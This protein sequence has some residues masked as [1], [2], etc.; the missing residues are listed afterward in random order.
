[1]CTLS[2]SHIK[3]KVVITSNRD[4]AVLRSQVT[5]REI[6]SDNN[7]I[8][9]L[10]DPLKKGT[11]LA[12][13][14]GGKVVVLLNGCNKKHIKQAHH[15]ESRGKIPLDFLIKN[16]SLSAFAKRY[17]FQNYEPFTM[18]ICNKDLIHELKWDGKKY[19]IFYVPKNKSHY[20]WSSVTLYNKNQRAKR[21]QLFE[22][23]IQSN[24]LTSES[25]FN[26]LS[27]PIDNQDNG[28]FLLR[29][30]VK[31]LSTSQVIIGHNSISLISVN[32]IEKGEVS[33]E[34]KQSE[35]VY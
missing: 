5:L 12:F 26:L 33:I 17:S 9:Y 4:D 14:S 32:H 18:V 6:K 28:F 35:K 7:K 21:Q 23:F 19:D 24:I 1:M 25:I 8:Y 15:T 3:T 16:V 2:I 10:E 11:W 22:Q 13:N 34:I 20:L 27:S 31:T 29:D 30:N